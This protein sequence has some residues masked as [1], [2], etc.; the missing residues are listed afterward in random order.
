VLTRS[1]YIMALGEKMRKK[2]GEDC[3]VPTLKD[4]QNNFNIFSEGA[5]VNMGQFHA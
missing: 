1:R 5:L 4:F 3:I 2:S